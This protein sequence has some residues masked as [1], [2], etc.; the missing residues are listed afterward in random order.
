[1]TGRWARLSLLGV[2]LVA[3]LPSYGRADALLPFW[4]FE[5][6][7]AG[8]PPVNGRLERFDENAG[9]LLFV[10]TDK[11]GFEGTVQAKVSGNAISMFGQSGRIDFQKQRFVIRSNDCPGGL[12]GAGY[13]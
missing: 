1:M 9:T 4:K 12:V 5:C 8:Q 10:I 7:G 13:R 6:V 2:C 3:M 11:D